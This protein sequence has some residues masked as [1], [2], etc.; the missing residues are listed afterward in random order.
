MGLIPLFS[1][2]VCGSISISALSERDLC[3]ICVSDGAVR[4]SDR[5]SPPLCVV[6]PALQE[7]KWMLKLWSYSF[8]GG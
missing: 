8:V 1:V 2:G 3:I 5:K 4:C 7:V 6:Q